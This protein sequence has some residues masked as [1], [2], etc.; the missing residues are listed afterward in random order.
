MIS[1]PLPCKLHPVEQVHEWSGFANYLSAINADQVVVLTDSNVFNTCFHAWS[2]QAGFTPNAVIEINPGEANKTLDT[3]NDVWKEMHRLRLTRN[4]LLICMGGGVVTDLGGFCASVFK[5]GIRCLHIPTSLLGQVDAALGGKTGV[6][7]DWLKNMI[8]TFYLPVSVLLDTNFLFTLPERHWANGF[9]EVIK[10]G[11]I[12]DAPLWADIQRQPLPS[13]Y[14]NE[15]S[16]LVL[17]AAAIKG[18]V[19]DQDPT[20]RGLRK[21]LNFGHTFG[22]GIET[23][24]L[25]KGYDI[26]HGEAIVAGM[27][28]EALLSLKLAGLDFR[29]Y[30]QITDWMRQQYGIID[31]PEELIPDIIDKMTHDKKNIGNKISFS[32][33]KQIGLAGYDYLVDDYDLLADIIRAYLK[34]L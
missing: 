17:R 28:M 23:V 11:L 6:D 25:E 7:Q 26:L 1:E 32:L 30:S 15:M 33:L 19:I 27:Q 29:E 2:E 4:S 22:H 14:K 18:I 10:H 31:I 20:E 34:D 16:A 24:L 21:I 12:A 13:Q 8:G 5:R 9:A 3:C